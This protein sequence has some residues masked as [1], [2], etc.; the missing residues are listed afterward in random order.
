MLLSE[1][2]KQREASLG[3][4][5]EED[6]IRFTSSSSSSSSSSSKGVGE[7][8]LLDQIITSNLDNNSTSTKLKSRSK[9]TIP[10]TN[11]KKSKQLRG[12]AYNDKSLSKKAS[13]HSRKARMEKYKRTY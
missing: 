6:F 11:L 1:R 13:K 3:E 2:R 7:S 5:H 10:I 8:T 12:Q 4:R 9:A